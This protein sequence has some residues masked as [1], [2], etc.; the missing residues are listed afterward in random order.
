MN[1]LVVLVLLVGGVIIALTIWLTLRPG[2]AATK[3]DPSNYR[4]HHCPECMRESMYS[5]SA[6][7]AIC[8]RCGK[9]LVPTVESVKE[10]T[11]RHS[12]WRRSVA[13]VLTECVCVLAVV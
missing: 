5:P 13:Y 2:M 12:P 3:V 4:F 6:G 10:S 8:A 9:K 11:G 7:D 1:R